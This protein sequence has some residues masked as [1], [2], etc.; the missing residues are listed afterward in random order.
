MLIGQHN[1]LGHILCAFSNLQD[2]QRT[3]MRKYTYRNYPCTIQPDDRLWCITGKDT[4]TGSGGVLE[5]AYDQKDADQLLE[6]MQASGEFINLSAHWAGI[7]EE[8]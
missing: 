5:W 2:N 4:V 6:V 7:K 8:S 3:T 1:R